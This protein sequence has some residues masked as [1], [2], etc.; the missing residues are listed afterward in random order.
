MPEG[1]LSLQEPPSL[2]ETQSAMGNMVTYMP[3][4]LSSLGMVLIFLKPGEGGGPLMYVAIGLMAV[5]AVGMLVSQI[6]RSSGDRKRK[7]R[8]ERRDYLRYL[9]VS[10]RRI[11]KL[12]D[13]QRQAQE[14][15]HPEPASLWSLVRTGR[16][17]ERRSTHEDFGEVRIAVGEQQL[18]MRLTP[19]STKPVEDL[20][21]LCAHALRRFIRAYGTVPDQ[22]VALYLRTYSRVLAHGDAEAARAMVRAVLGQLSV[23]HAP[24]DLRIAVIT[25]HDRREDWEWTKWLPHAQHPTETDG[26]GAVRLVADSAAGLEQLLGDEFAGRPP[27][28]PDAAPSAEEPYYVIVL[29]HPG[30]PGDA[31]LAGEGYR[32]VVTLDIGGS[33]PWKPGR[34]SLRLRVSAE[35]LEM[36]R[37]ERT[38]KEKTTL[39]GRPDALGPQR[40]RALA[41]LLSPYRMGVTVDTGEALTSDVQLTSL[42]GVPDLYTMDVARVHASRSAA[43]R[44]RVPLGVSGDG[45]PVELDIKEAAQ[46]GMG[47]HGMLIGATGSGKSELLRTLVLALALTHSSE[48]LNLILVDFKGGATFLGLD[49]L[50]HT[51]AV[52][53]NLADE[54]ALVDRM[55]DALHGEMMRRQE[56]L[57]SA[58]NYT[59]ALEYETARDGGADLV[60]LPTL[61]VVVDEFSELLSAHRDFMDLFVM[62]GR[63]GRSLGVHLLLASQRLDEGRMHQ[64][65]SHLSYRVALRTFSAMESR[66]VLGVPDAYQ[67]PSVPGSAILKKD[68]GALVRFKAAYVSGTYQGARRVGQSVVADQVVPYRTGWVAPRVIDVPDEPAE[69]EE[70]SESLLTVAVQRLAGSGPPAHTVWLPPLDVPPSM[71]EMLPQLHA[72]PERG[73]T[74]ADTSTHATLRVPVG[75]V[76]RPFEQTREPLI[77]DLSGA[78]GHIGIAGGPQSGKSTLLRSL[79]LGLALTHTPREVQFY[80]LDFGG[81]ALGGLRDLPHVGG[82]TGRLDLERVHRTLAE[83]NALV[84]RRETQFADLGI[85]SMATLRARRAAGELP[86]EP[87]GDVF[88]VIDGW[89]TVRQDFLD[90]M[91][92]FATLASRGLNYGVHLVVASTRWAEISTALRDQLG[93]RFE[94]RLG[95]TMDSMINMRAAATV[96]KNPGRGLTDSQH[97]FLT[98]LPRLDGS[99]ESADLGAGVADAVERVSRNWHGPCAPQVRTLPAVLDA[100]ALPASERAEGN[101]RVPLGLDGRDLDVLWHDFGQNPHLVVVGDSETGKTNLLRSVCR[102][103]AERYAPD[104][105]KVMLVDYRRDLLECVPEEHRLGYA[106]SVDVLKQVVD[107]V[108]RAMRERL[109]GQDITPAQLKR[110]DWWEG[111]ELFMVIDDY[112]MVSGGS[113]SNHFGP[114][115]DYL[116]QGVELGLHLIVARSAN[117]ASRAMS[118]ALLRRLLEVNTPALLMSCPPSEGYLFG[119]IKPMQLPVGRALHIT[120]RGIV[121]VQ[122]ALGEESPAEVS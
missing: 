47:P 50:P 57:R 74:P 40:A 12:I 112:D 115:L 75:I 109:P 24:Q 7:L 60:P 13:Q 6:I 64:L 108:S 107:G 3:M 101:L 18:G 45:N 105:A 87:Y 37:T 2:P 27:F 89:T 59:S 36:V 113:M 1:E 92:T 51:S 102:A 73:L 80:C 19:L 53:T 97:H 34:G 41:R 90:I 33:F 48:K 52:I 21:P 96:P 30:V 100:A 58:G 122:T 78:G 62:V 35:K 110:R 68:T 31:R 66:G 119:D 72:D 9:S 28:D 61:F 10:R 93:T 79:I 77:A 23:L 94:L 15:R 55:K 84:A 38:G 63:L 49:S 11:R 114:M 39:L 20:E 16:L 116:A 99:G 32:N 5:S 71:D 91:P 98:A 70:T 56:L 85:D 88:L 42:L 67:L 121:Q 43:A 104:E 17:W 111:P 22:P 106:V 83:V 86:D 95:D 82:V 117:G 26:A 76:D 25:D 65:E 8:G 54:S 103:V 81:G 4:A 69:S 29:D 14:W 46:G 118:D 120:R 44:L